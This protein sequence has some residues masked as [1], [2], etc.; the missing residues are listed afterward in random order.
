MRYPGFSVLCFTAAAFFAGNI[1]TT[2]ASRTQG[3]HEGS[4]PARAA[5]AP[6]AKTALF[7]I[8]EQAVHDAVME[9]MLSHCLDDPEVVLSL[10]DTGQKGLLGL[11]HVLRSFL[12]EQDP[13]WEPQKRAAMLELLGHLD[14][15]QW[16]LGHLRYLI[17]NE[18]KAHQQDRP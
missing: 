12:N 6:A 4:R 14:K 11:R 10:I 13:G 2:L 8:D 16:P 3:T 18:K 9:C 17:D 5:P 15:A 1:A 7:R